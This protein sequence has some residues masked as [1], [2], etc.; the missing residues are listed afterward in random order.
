MAVCLSLQVA[1]FVPGTCRPAP[2]PPSGGGEED[3]GELGLVLWGLAGL[4]GM[5]MGGEWSWVKGC[6]GAV[7]WV[8][9][10]PWVFL[11]VWS[12]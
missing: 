9:W 1:V 8:V 5:D 2:L 7:V 11:V 4:W 6:C 12:I 3:G 10:D